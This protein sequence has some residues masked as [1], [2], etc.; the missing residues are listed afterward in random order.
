[1]AKGMWKRVKVGYY[2][3]G[4]PMWC[5]AVT[6]AALDIQGRRLGYDLTLLQASYNSSVGASAN[7]HAKGRVV[8]LAP[9]EAQEKQRAGRAV[10]WASF[11]RLAVPGVWS[12]HVHQCL[13]IKGVPDTTNIDGLAALQIKGYRANPPGDGLG[14]FPFGHA[15]GWVPNPRVAFD[16]D[17]YRAGR[18]GKKGHLHDAKPSR[19]SGD[20]RNP[21]IRRAVRN[22]RRARRAAQNPRRR[23][24]LTQLI[25]ELLPFMNVKPK[26]NIDIEHR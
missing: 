23:D 8:D 6:V 24:Q 15:G 16:W 22:L 3:D 19:S 13:L 14:P 11:R 5:D 21:N 12:E 1:M 4:R 9:F 26:V 18:Y 20:R 10:G 2:S 7:T 17:A 25:R